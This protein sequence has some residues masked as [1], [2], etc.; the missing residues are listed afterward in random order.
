MSISC[1]MDAQCSFHNLTPSLSHRVM[2]VLSDSTPSPYFIQIAIAP[3]QSDDI[4][5]L[6]LL[7]I[8]NNTLLQRHT[9][10]ELG[11]S[12]HSHIIPHYHITLRLIFKRYEV[13]SNA[14]LDGMLASLLRVFGRSD[15]P[16]LYPEYSGTCTLSSMHCNAQPEWLCPSCEELYKH[17]DF[18]NATLGRDYHS[19]Q[20]QLSDSGK[21]LYCESGRAN[22][23]PCGLK[24]TIR[25]YTS[26]RYW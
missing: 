9:L 16:Q 14:H 1:T 12:R 22:H 5:S 24:G 25:S 11:D 18:G 2:I 4:H 13:A 10:H 15:H 20:P 3:K 19:V 23:A 17:P 7:N 8:C 26:F 21:P 6:P